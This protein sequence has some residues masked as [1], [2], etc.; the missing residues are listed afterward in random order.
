MKFSLPLRGRVVG[1][2]RRPGGAGKAEGSHLADHARQV[3]PDRQ[4]GIA[5]GHQAFT[6]QNGVADTNLACPVFGVVRRAIDFNHHATIPTEEVQYIAP[7]RRLTAKVK[8]FA[9]KLT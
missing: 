7:H 5:H 4:V 3:I 2:K 9:T 6:C 1:A 8:A